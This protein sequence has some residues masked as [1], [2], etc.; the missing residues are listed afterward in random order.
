VSSIARLGREY[1]EYEKAHPIIPKS[2]R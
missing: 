2:E 1:W